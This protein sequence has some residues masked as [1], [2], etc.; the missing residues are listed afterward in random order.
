MLNVKDDLLAY[1]MDIKDSQQNVVRSFTGEKSVPQMIQWDGH[2]QNETVL[3]DGEYHA[4]MSGIYR[5]GN[6][7]TVDSEQFVLD[8]TPPDIDVTYRPKLFSP[9]NDGNDDDMTIGIAASDLTGIE[10]WKLT[11]MN[12][13]RTR[14]FISF[15]GKGNPTPSIVW[16]GI[17][18][19]GELVESAEDY[20]V[21]ITAV[22]N[23]GNKIDKFVKP[24]EVDILVEKLDDGRLKIRISNIEFKPNSSQMTDSD[25]NKK[26]IDRLS[27]ALKKYSSYNVTIEGHANRFMTSGKFLD[28]VA[29]KLSQD[30][31]DYIMNALI[32]KGIAKKRLVT[33]SKSGDEPVFTPPEGWQKGLSREEFQLI[34]EKIG[35]NRRVEFYLDKN[36]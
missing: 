9:D 21:R 6:R 34:K 35:K 11:V 20:P 25:K 3:P 4:T 15:G 24:I 28:D 27:V 7:P 17:S 30:R 22:D 14:E 16:N 5:F 10:E 29:R 23:V 8:N 18:S 1:K 26:I 32:G 19:E 33:T 31:A 2:D 13:T 12:P 36:N